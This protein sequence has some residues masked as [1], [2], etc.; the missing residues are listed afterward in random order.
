MKHLSFALGALA[1]FPAVA[2]AQSLVSIGGAGSFGSNGSSNPGTLDD[3]VTVGSARYIFTLDTVASQL[4]VRVENTSPVTA[5]VPNPVLTDVFFNTPPAVTGMS[6]ASQTGSGGA[7]PLWVLNFDADL[8]SNPNPNGA[9]GFGAYNVHLTTLGGGIVGAIANPDADT[10]G[11]PPLTA[12]IGPVTFVLDLTGDLTGLTD[13][14]FTSLLSAN[15]PGNEQFVAAGKFQAGGDAGASGFI[16]PGEFCEILATSVSVP[17][18]CGDA[19]LSTSLPLMGTTGT[20]SLTNAD[21]QVCALVLGSAGTG[22]SIN[23]NGCTLLVD[24][25]TVFRLKSF[26][27]DDNGEGSFEVPMLSFAQSPTCCGAQFMIQAATLAKGPGGEV[28]LLEMTNGVQLTL[29]N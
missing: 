10:L 29:G 8:G 20:V 16:S 3:G 15:P 19:T 17:G 28:T 6:I 12:V 14:D 2:T 26:V 1:L 18:G 24:P 9:N 5:G 22:T 4:E 21:P 11:V 13:D 27:T 7:P 25:N 23:F